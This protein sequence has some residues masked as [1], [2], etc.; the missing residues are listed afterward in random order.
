MKKKIKNLFEKSKISFTKECFK[1]NCSNPGVYKAPKSKDE[2]RNYIWF[3]D[4]H[5][6]EYNKSWDYCKNM[7]QREIENHIQL[8]T[9]GWRPTWDFSTRSFNLKNFEKI[10]SNYFNFFNKTKTKKNNYMYNSS[11]KN[12][13]QILKINKKNVSFK[14][15]ENKYKELVKKYHPDRNKGNKIYEEKLKK[16]NLAFSEI[17][18][19]LVTKF[20]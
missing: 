13:F 12:A 20:N 18:K 5:I 8:D 10:I 14:A 15:I 2:L 4:E 9:I 6:K 19:K 3:C 7:S 1:K 16:I 17:K 11:L